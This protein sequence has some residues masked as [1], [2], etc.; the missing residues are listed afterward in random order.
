MKLRKAMAVILLVTLIAG[1]VTAGLMAYT[2]KVKTNIKVE[3]SVVL[4]GVNYD[5]LIIDNVTGIGGNTV[6]TKHELNV[7]CYTPVNLTI[8]TTSV[9]GILTYYEYYEGVILHSFTNPHLFET[10][11]HTLVFNYQLDLNLKP[12]TYSVTSTLSVTK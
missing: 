5:K 10:G 4:D 12:A 7:R 11:N 3:Q 2:N 9:S 1:L 8:M 6:K